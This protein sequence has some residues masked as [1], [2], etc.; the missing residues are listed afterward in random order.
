MS[1]VTTCAVAPVTVFAGA[2]SMLLLSACTIVPTTGRVPVG[3]GGVSY[4]LTGQSQAS[5]TV[6]FQS[7]LGDDKSVWSPVLPSLQRD[8]R[9]FA[10]D[11][12]G[13]GGSA[14]V[15]GKRDACSI[16]AEERQVLHAAGVRP[17]YVLVGHSIGGLYQYVFA[18]MYPDEV[19]GI[20]LLDP[21]HPQLWESMQ[22][23]SPKTAAVLKTVSAMSGPTEKREFDDQV[24]CIERIDTRQP[25]HV[26][27]RVLTSTKT[28]PLVTSDLKDVV[29]RLSADWERMT[30]AGR[31]EPVAG[32]SHYIQTDAPRAVIAA[33][34]SVVAQARGTPLR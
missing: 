5:P 14:A 31:V 16:A 15:G 8:N 7:G 13:Y 11:R 32:A 2:A 12:P 9:V 26:P 29:D 33:I 20:V 19:A 17:P 28:S 27:A 24:A 1:K 30:G 23:T 22:R 21:M 18:K 10:Y 25:L 3:T 4:S 34:E 6:V